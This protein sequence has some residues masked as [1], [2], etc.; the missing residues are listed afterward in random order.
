MRNASRRRLLLWA[1]ADLGLVLLIALG[2]FLYLFLTNL[3]GY[4]L[5]KT[6][7]RNP[8]VPSERI[9]GVNL[10]VHTYGDK[11]QPL[12]VGLHDGPGADSYSLKTLEALSDRFH[13]VLYDRRGCGLSE[14][15]PPERLRM[16]SLLA[17]LGALLDR[18]APQKSVY[19]AGQGF[20]AK[21][22]A[23][24]AARHPAKIRSLVLLS[25]GA[26]VPGVSEAPMLLRG[27]CPRWERWRSTFRALHVRVKSDPDGTK[28]YAFMDRWRSRPRYPDCGELPAP[29]LWRGGHRAAKQLR[30]D[31]FT[32]AGELRPAFAP[33]LQAYRGPL[34]LAVGACNEATGA[35]FFRRQ[36]HKLPARLQVDELPGCGRFPFSEA[37]RTARRYVRQALLNQ[38]G[39]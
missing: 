35:A 30:R 7:S 22:G 17:E 8:L 25:P 14:R 26:L 20:G 31:V 12:L 3:D 38:G 13:V 15:V 18:L 2:G 1:I 21:L 9:R 19:V 36:S 24:Y 34:F 27:R 39:S 23:L 16:D 37:P 32:P 5:S 6:V 10:H 33:K 29:Q 11:D 4:F 28:D